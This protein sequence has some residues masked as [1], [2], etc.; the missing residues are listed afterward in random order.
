MPVHQQG[1]KAILETLF[2]GAP[3][4]EQFYMWLATNASLAKTS[5][6][7]DVVPIVDPYYTGPISVTPDQFTSTPGTNHNWQVYIPLPFDENV[8]DAN[9]GTILLATTA[10]ASGLLIASESYGLRHLYVCANGHE[11][12]VPLTLIHW[13]VDGQ[14]RD[15]RRIRWNP[16]LPWDTAY[17][18][19]RTSTGETGND[20]VPENY[21]ACPICRTTQFWS[22]PITI[23]ENFIINQNA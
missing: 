20:P 10:D 13:I 18:H 22:C 3:V 14:E 8:W 6:L 9:V 21:F 11:F 16:R 17:T 15:L 4:P 7:A 2:C 19:W 1:L 12:D 23:P 5:T